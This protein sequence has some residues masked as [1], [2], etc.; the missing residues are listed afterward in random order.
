[1]DAVLALVLP[2][3]ATGHLVTAIRAADVTKP[4]AAVVL[5]QA[6]AVSLLPRATTDGEAEA[7]GQ[8][9]FIPSYA[10]PEAAAHALAR[11]AT[12]GA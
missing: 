8:P 2:T 3:A 10:Y 6:E 1:M 5:D 4:L 11:A 7:A 12:Y 9:R